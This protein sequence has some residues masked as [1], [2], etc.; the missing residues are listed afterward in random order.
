[1]DFT[2][3]IFAGKFYHTKYDLHYLYNFYYFKALIQH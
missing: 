1:M 2:A 3:Q